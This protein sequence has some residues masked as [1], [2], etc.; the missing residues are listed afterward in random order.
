MERGVKTD[1]AIVLTEMVGIKLCLRLVSLDSLWILQRLKGMLI[2]EE[3][4]EVNGNYESSTFLSK[5]DRK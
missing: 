4:S 2:R 3:D 1:S 5:K